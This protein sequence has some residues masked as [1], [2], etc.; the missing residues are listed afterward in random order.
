[1]ITL[2][3][4][5]MGRDRSHALQLGTD[6][7]ANARRTIELSNMLLVLAKGAGVRIEESPRTKTIVT[8]GWRPVDVNATTPGAAPKSHHIWAKA[9]DLYDPDGEIDNWIYAN[10]SVLSDL[11]L[12]SEHPASTKGWCH[13]QTVPPRSGRRIF[14]P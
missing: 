3:D 13:I 4:Y 6:I 7:R 14:Y 8:S 5:W 11:G 1:M 12:W 2:A 9:I 10:D